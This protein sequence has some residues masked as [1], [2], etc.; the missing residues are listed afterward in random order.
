[1][2]SKNLSRHS[3]VLIK[4]TFK[5]GRRYLV[6]YDERWDCLLFPNYRHHDDNINFL[7]DVLKEDFNTDFLVGYLGNK[8]HQKFSV[9][10]GK[11]KIYRHKFY[12]A[13]GKLPKFM[14]ED[15]FEINGKK[16]YWKTLEEL[17]E[18][19]DVL[20]KNSDIIGYVEEYQK[21]AG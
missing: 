10:A 17:K 13:S 5:Y 16:F 20:K 12:T 3:I 6:Y 14:Q 4:D 2:D 19:P 18:N 1:M 8:I 9:S 15:F 11:D 7:N 21:I